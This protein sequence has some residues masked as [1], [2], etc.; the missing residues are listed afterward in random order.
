MLGAATPAGAQIYKVGSFT[1][2]AGTAVAF[3]STQ[4]ASVAAALT[5]TTPAITPAGRNRLLVVGLSSDGVM[6]ALTVKYGGVPL[7]IVPGSS[8]TNGATHTELWTLVA[9][10]TTA[11][12]V[13][14]LWTTTARTVVIGAV[15]F[16]NV[17]QAV[18]PQSGISATGTSTAPAVT[19]VSEPGDFTMA[20]AGKLTNLGAETP[21]SRWHDVSRA[22]QKGGG[23]TVTGAANVAHTW[24]ASASSTVWSASGVNIKQVGGQTNVVPHGLGATPTALLLWSSGSTTGAGFA[25]SVWQSFGASDGTTSR[26]VGTMSLTGVTTTAASRRA[27]AK[28]ITFIKYGQVPQAE[29]DV[30]WDGTNFTLTWTMNNATAYVIHYMVMSV[31]SA[32]MVDWT[33]SLPGVTGDRGVG[34]GFQPNLIISFQGF[35]SDQRPSRRLRRRLHVRGGGLGHRPVGQWLSD[36]LR[37]G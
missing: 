27:S 22:N 5:V 12:T 11:A 14:A 20:V 17:D 21:V 30:S 10:S 13:V 31:V 26:A 15:A 25:N 1:K 2:T 19:V 6:T 32:K 18:G 4:T 24:A 37:V 36:C 34:V 28:A 23:S 16:S 29:A 35:R 3:A 33:T 8:V 9:P 7:T